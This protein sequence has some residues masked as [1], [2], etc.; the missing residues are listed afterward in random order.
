VLSSIASTAAQA[1][2][3]SA[4]AQ[5]RMYG[6]GWIPVLDT[7]GVPQSAAA[8]RC[9]A[10]AR[11]QGQ[12]INNQSDYVFLLQVCDLFGVFDAA[13]IA[14]R[15]GSDAASFAAGLT[16]AMTTFESANVLGGRLRLSSK[17][18]DGPGVFAPFGYLSSCTC[19]RYARKPSA[20]A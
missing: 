3:Y 1:G 14:A 10:I 4:S 17:A 7:T 11:S 20:L 16:S 8:K 19:F 15:G 6:V 9:L 5:Q 13:L 2:Q 18:H 12:I